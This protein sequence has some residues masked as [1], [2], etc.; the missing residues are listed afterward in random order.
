MTTSCG[1]RLGL[2]HS[3][4]DNDHGRSIEVEAGS[5]PEEFPPDDGASG[6]RAE[7]G[8]MPEFAVSRDH[9]VARAT[10]WVEG[11]EIEVVGVGLTQCEHFVQA[12]QQA[13]DFIASVLDEEVA[14][15]L[16]EVVVPGAPDLHHVIQ[17]SGIARDQW[18]LVTA[19]QAA[20]VGIGPDGRA[21]L[22]KMGVLEWTH[23]DDVW[24][25]TAAP[26]HEK[27]MLLATWLAVGGP[28]EHNTLVAAGR[29]AA[30]LYG[31]GVYFIDEYEFVS[32]RPISTAVDGVEIRQ[33]TVPRDDVLPV[34][35]IPTLRPAL[36]VADLVEH[37][38][39]DL[40]NIAE[41]VRDFAR[42]GSQIGPE[43]LDPLL[44]PHAATWGEPEGDG[45]ALRKRLYWLAGVVAVDGLAYLEVPGSDTS[46]GTT[47]APN[48]ADP[49]T[50]KPQAGQDAP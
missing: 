24:Q 45:A 22:M 5:E 37:G 30:D 4:T 29:T 36:M 2:A 39:G 28:R 27:Q 21:L 9:F 40:T 43:T 3:T 46:G 10:P 33:S 20:Y 6:S 25:M 32:S 17:L 11:W 50:Q 16:V 44:A 13:A 47:G 8:N 14:T 34:H 48:P 41:V 19:D 15:D 26:T 49:Q 42:G 12:R 23:V 7:G 1:R 31:V 38:R 35:G 18:G